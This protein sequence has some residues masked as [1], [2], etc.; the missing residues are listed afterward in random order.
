[1]IQY[2]DEAVSACENLLPESRAESEAAP[3]QPLDDRE[4]AISWAEACQSVGNILTSMGFVEESY[5]WRSMAF[6]PAPDSAK[7]YATSGRAYC[8]CKL[9]E[10]AI[11]FCEKT[12]EH[13]PNNFSARQRLAKAYNELGDR[14]KE[15]DMVNELLAIDPSSTTAEGH[16]Q[17][18]QMLTMQGKRAQAIDCYQRAIDQ[19]AGY[20]DAYD[21]LATIWNQ[22]GEWPKSVELFKTF[23]ERESI[24]S[25]TEAMAHYQMGRAYRQGQETELA[26]A[27]FRKALKLDSQMHWAYMGLLNTLMQMQRWDEIIEICQSIVR[28]GEKF[29]WLYCFMGNALAKKGDDAQAA[30]YQ[31]QAFAY[32]GWSGCKEQNYQFPL[33][34]FS[35]NI[36]LWEQCLATLNVHRADRDPLMA[37]SVGSSDDSILFWLADK[38]LQQP[39]DQ[40]VCMTPKIS[41]QLQE[42]LTKLPQPEKI[43]T[44]VGEQQQ[45][46]ERSE[47]RFDVIIIQSDRKTGDYVQSLAAQ[48]WKALK[49]GGILF[50]KDYLWQHP[51]DPGQSSKAGIDAFIA[52]AALQLEVL[53]QAHQVILKKEGSS[54][55]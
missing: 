53:H 27:C 33:T 23:L 39:D 42:N 7:F 51:T 41:P 36:P 26:I 18:G 49:P 40:L 6:D 13:Q 2:L 21:A 19:D 1:M 30:S 48:A 20:F 38:V 47:R 32:K 44:E 28:F 12:L 50:F 55:A 45:L 8:Q 14:R 10:R 37:L 24:E 29:P 5:P 34:W 31:Q 25:A 11:Y 46:L 4:L 52:S 9:W 54:V 17:M 22:R 35:E 43:V 3:E 15:S 16:Y